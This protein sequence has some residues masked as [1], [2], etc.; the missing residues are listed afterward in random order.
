MSRFNHLK[1]VLSLVVALLG[2]A[3]LP[4]GDTPAG[5]LTYEGF[6][7]AIGSNLSGRDGGFGWGGAWVDVGGGGGVSVNAGNLMANGNGPIGFDAGSQSNSVLAANG[8]RIG[9]RLDTATNGVF[10]AAGLL[11][12][13][14]EIGADGQKVYLS[15][16]QQ[17]SKPIKFYEFE[18]HRSD[19]GDPGRIA[20]IGNDAG[21]D[22]VYWRSQSPAGGSS[23][24][25]N[26]GAGNT[27]VNFYIVRI[28]FKSGNDDVYIYRNPKGN[29]ES[30]N[31]PVLTM[32]AISDMSF[33]GLS[34]ASYVNGVTV[35]H[36]EIRVGFTWASV[37]GDPP[38]FVVQPTNQNLYAGQSAVL[39]SVAQSGRP[40]NYQWYK[41]A[42]EITNALTRET[43]ANLSFPVVQLT[44]AGKY[45]V[46]VSNSLGGATSFA[47]TLTVQPIAIA[48]DGSQYLNLGAGSN[49][50]IN[51]SVGGMPPVALQWYKDGEALANIT[52]ATLAFRLNG[53][54]DAGQ[55]MLV[56][57]NAFGMVTSSVIYAAANLGG[58][59]A[60]EGFG[61]GQKSSDIGG[62]NGGL[63][64]AGAWV[65]LNGNASQ[66]YSNSLVT[67]AGAPAGYDAHSLDG[68][69]FSANASR[70]G[71]YLNCS[72]T[73]PFAQRG[74]LDGAG[75]I[76]ADGTTI[77]FSFLQK[78]SALSKFYEFEIKRNDLGDGGRIAGI[79]NDTGDTRV[80][81]RIQAPAGGNST[82]YDLG[83]GSTNV[84][85]YV[86]RIDYQ[87]G[88]DTVRVYRNPTSGAE[89]TIPT[90]VLSNVA[91]LSF[92][93][94]SLAA[95]DNNVAVS[96]DE[97]RVGTTWQDVLGNNLSQLQ[98]AQRT[99]D[100]THLLVAG[101]PNYSYQ[102]Q[103]A[104]NALGPW[105]NLRSVTLPT[106]GVGQL[107]DT[108]ALGSQRFYRALN[109]TTAADSSATDTSIADF[110]Q[111][112]YGAWV[113]SGTAFGPGPAQGGFPYQG[114]VSGY[115]GSGL[116]DSYYN[117]DGT[118]GTLTSP[119]FI[120]TRQYLNFLIGGGNHPGQTC[121]NLIV[122]NLMV[123][124]ATGFDN[125]MLTPMQWDVSSYLGQTAILKI[126]DTATGGWGHINI[127][128]IALSD[129]AFPSLSRTMLLTNK[130]LNLPVKD[131]AAIKRVTVTVGG[132]IVRDFNIG[133][134]DGTPDWW[135]FVDVSAFSNQTATISI[136]ALN[137]GSRGLSAVL[138]ANG[139]VG[140]TNLYSETLRPQLHFSSK[141]GWLNDA[142][143]MVYYGGM[144][145]LYY[146]HNPFN[147]DGTDQK[148]WGHA[149]SSDMVN[150]VELPE[151]LYPHAYGDWVWS[152]SAVVDINNTGGF[153][154]GTNDVIVAA[155][156]STARGECIAYSNDGGLT[157]TDFTNNPVVV[158]AG[159]G[160]DPHV[161]W[162]AP[163]NYWVMAVYDETG[164]SGIQ[165]LSSPDLKQWTYRSKIMNFFEC[166]DLIRLPLDGN[167]NN[168][169]WVLYAANSDYMVGQF[170]GVAF[171]P[172]TPK[173]PGNS[174]GGFY[175]AQTFTTMPSGD[176]RCV[177]I[178]WAIIYMP[179]MPFNQMMYFP[180]ELKLKTT[181]AGVRLFNTSVAEITNNIVN[182]YSWTNLTLSP[183]DNPLSG[184]RGGLFHVKAQF[185][186]GSAQAI[187]LG[188]QTV[189]LTYNASSQ[190]ITCNGN[191]Q[192][193]PLVNG[194]V[195]LEIIAD[196]NSIEI[197]GNDGQLYMPIPASNA[198]SD[199]RL[200]LTCV[201][202]NASFT[203]LKVNKLKSIW[204][205]ASY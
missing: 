182:T 119:P 117:G 205:R 72:A 128:Q 108:N 150:W 104:T 55:Y 155:Y 21:D 8:N 127:D 23:T 190:Q 12:A 113:T 18:F 151:A 65:N 73:G 97:I 185:S 123:M 54:F 32:L 133:L 162:Y 199:L 60:Y 91:D 136:N 154:N 134:A 77:Y 85:L 100:A 114:A 120:I 157:F 158:H 189:V 184:I 83:T 124:T 56:A 198:S 51:A 39:S 174:G 38:T 116:V 144:Y 172:S 44:D 143:G 201:G 176:P 137:L 102:I 89:P 109:G 110:E 126:V 192:S 106:L 103:I 196:R 165:F 169:Q 74:Y 84:S 130:F 149:I 6:N 75:H 37:L 42:N 63:G 173:L 200:S 160:R 187:N 5:I 46:T 81:L 139:I 177:R 26:L 66:S 48:L 2:Q 122:S 15:F 24:F 64:W 183:G 76:G 69:L 47:A 49:L 41:A 20:G 22:N 148:Y 115:S 153:K 78:P 71:R 170:D 93:G 152:G 131:G 9:R 79:G 88:N 11:D 175:A 68:Y 107:V 94:I 142:N 101:S 195:Q 43:N 168:M 167:T 159:I 163:S 52:N 202:G 40:F 179:G 204:S 181:A 180:T 34:L 147:W 194:S 45:F 3:T 92:D 125:E 193:L 129:V 161:L 121:I 99:N 166:P 191:T 138:Q 188:F 57:S 140:D 19:L 4:A 141:R 28:D 17:P 25:W 53:P 105:K 178:G 132:N 59:L 67:K 36:D 112:T 203:S 156:T 80:H 10:E 29:S 13:N 62:A 16:L 1:P 70:K 31:E 27:N 14:R 58:L 146:Q 61:Y 164:G 90:L 96:H 95:Y 98:L 111:A 35:K 145:H 186:V 171:I 197:F 87:P 30:D 118:T 33:D 50:V 82:F 135:A 7:Y 86:V